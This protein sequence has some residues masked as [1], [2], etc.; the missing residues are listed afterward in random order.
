VY[1]YIGDMIIS[2]QNINVLD[3]SKISSGM[4]TLQIMYENKMINKKILKQ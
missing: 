4:Y 2:K 1:N 3:M